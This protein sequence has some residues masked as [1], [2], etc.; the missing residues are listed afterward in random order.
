[1][2]EVSY[3]VKVYFRQNLGKIFSEVILRDSAIYETFQPITFDKAI[4]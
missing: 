2:S 3:I 1:M 4:C